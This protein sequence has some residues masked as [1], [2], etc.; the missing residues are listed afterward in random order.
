MY[1]LAR[2]LAAVHGLAG[3]GPIGRPAKG[4]G[5][6]GA[7]G[8]GLSAM[9]RRACGSLEPDKV[10]ELMKDLFVRAQNVAMRRRTR[11]GAEAIDWP[12]LI[13]GVEERKLKPLLHEQRAEQAVD[14]RLVRVKSPRRGDGDGGGGGRG[15]GDGA[16]GDAPISKRKK[17]NQ[18]WQ[19]KQAARAAKPTTGALASTDVAKPA[20]GSK[21]AAEASE[22][23]KLN[24]Q[25]TAVVL[26]GGPP[27]AALAPNSISML[28]DKTT[29]AGAVEAL[30]ALYI[31][32]TGRRQREEQP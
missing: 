27:A 19:E 16:G 26:Q 32:R 29:H 18:E 2:I 1:H 23:E 6:A 5:A 11:R 22:Q 3:G 4:G 24:R 13:A 14:R 31:E 7:D 25:A 17:K 8:L 21:A 10:D 30:A 15:G 9:A 20:K 12:A 28:G